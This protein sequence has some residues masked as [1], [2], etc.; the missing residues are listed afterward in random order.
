MKV[1]QQYIQEASQNTNEVEKIIKTFTSKE[2]EWTGP[3]EFYNESQYRRVEWKNN[4][5]ACFLEARIYKRRAKVNIGCAKEFRG[6][7]MMKELWKTSIKELKKMGIIII[8]A[9]VFHYRAG[10]LPTIKT[11]RGQVTYLLF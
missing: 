11:I 7:G 5:P 2:K 3:R 8:L 6:K 9:A 4:K 1:I 10:T